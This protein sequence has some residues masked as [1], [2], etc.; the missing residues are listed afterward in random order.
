MT[1]AQSVCFTGPRE[2]KYSYNHFQPRANQYLSVPFVCVCKIPIDDKW[3]FQYLARIIN[4]LKSR[5]STRICVDD[6][7]HFR[8]N[9]WRI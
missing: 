8:F 7:D 5:E 3:E 1:E 9:H 4:H 2:Y 6:V